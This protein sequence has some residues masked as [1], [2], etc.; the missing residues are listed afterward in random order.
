MTNEGWRRRS[1]LSWMGGAAAALAIGSKPAGAQPAPGAF[2]PARH[3]ED[4]WFDKIPGKHRVILDVT[5]SAGIGEG[6]GFTSNLFTANKTGYG[7]DEGDLAIVVCLR[8]DATAF[9]FADP[10]WVKFG[11][12]IAEAAKYVD[13]RA[14][15]PPTANPYNRAPR[16]TLETLARRGVRFAVCDLSVHRYSRQLAGTG[17]DAD[18]HYKELVANLVPNGRLVPAGV[19]GVTR[20]QE[21]GYSLVSVG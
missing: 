3:P 15:E 14:T 9:A 12:A 2:Q 10:M 17:G 21:Y 1:W 19:V 16:K 5:S 11:K 4:D 20:A 6:L 18:A 8:H 13:P 7:L